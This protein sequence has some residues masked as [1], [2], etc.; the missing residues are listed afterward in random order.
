MF[1]PKNNKLGHSIERFDTIIGQSLRVEG[2]LIVSQA[3]RVDGYVNGNIFQADSETATVAVADGAMVNGD[4]RASHVIISGKLKGNI[5]SSA[6]VEI[7][8]TAEIEGDIIFGSL[9]IEIGARVTGKLSPIE[10]SEPEL[11]S[12]QLIAQSSQQ[13]TV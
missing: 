5:F 2:N 10:R 1:R 3:T 6:R 7:L 12:M 4:I 8:K 11:S 9:G 13:I